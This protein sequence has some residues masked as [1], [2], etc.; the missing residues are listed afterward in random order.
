M[1]SVKNNGFWELE[2]LSNIELYFAK[3]EY[4]KENSVVIE[5]DD[6]HHITRVMRHS[7]GDEIYVTNG[8]GKIFRCEI[9]S[10]NKNEVTAIV[11]EEYSYKNKYGKF[12]F[13]LPKLKSSDR[14]E[15]A[16]EKTIE[17]GISNF[18]V[19]NSTRTVSK[20]T[21]MQRWNK[22]AVAAMKQSLQSYLPVI[23]E[24]DSLKELSELDGE[25]VVFEQNSKKHLSELSID[26]A[27]NYYFVF[28]PEGGLDKLELDLFDGSE[29][30]NLAENRLRAET[31]VIKAAAILSTLI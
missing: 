9:S 4:F 18:I 27:K 15:F 16:L 3:P 30:S 24:V 12:T 1:I 6:F 14:F 11:K 26:P 2:H 29:I 5:G 10:L 20:G 31:A 21:K 19:F 22:I 28:G 7:A 23:S 25:I 13:C 8:V 17:L